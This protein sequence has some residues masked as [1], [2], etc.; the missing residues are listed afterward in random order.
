MV[1]TRRLLSLLVLQLAWASASEKEDYTEVGDLL[2]LKS[3]PETCY[4]KLFEPGEN[5]KPVLPGQIIPAGLQVRLSLENDF[6]EAK[7]AEGHDQNHGNLLAPAAVGG[8]DNNKKEVEYK[9]KTKPKKHAAV[10]IVESETPFAKGLQYLQEVFKGD[11]IPRKLTYGELLEHLNAVNDL[12][13]DIENGVAISKLSLKPLLHL[14][15]LY[16]EN[17][18]KSF[19]LTFRQLNN[20]KDLSYKILSATFRNNEEAQAV[21]LSHLTDQ[22]GFLEKLVNH[23]DNA[24]VSKSRLGF[25]GSLLNNSQFD[26]AFIQGEIETQLLKLYSVNTDHGIKNRILL[27]L[28]DRDLNKRDI[29]NDDEMELHQSPDERYAKR[30]ESMLIKTSV[31]TDVEAQQLLDHLKTM[32]LNRDSVFKASAPFLDWLSQEIETAKSDRRKRG[33]DSA[34]VDTLIELRHEVFG[35]RLGSRKEFIDDL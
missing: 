20:V 19:G 11:R 18:T 5:W 16:D 1:L 13:S 26:H 17:N 22:V 14:T 29:S 34:M 35:N 8:G 2:C 30:I 25:L 28:E 21:L 31:S 33:L 15:G 24:L 7:Y 32:K 23:E 4:P 12:A 10:A 9:H 6:R 3:N 27:I